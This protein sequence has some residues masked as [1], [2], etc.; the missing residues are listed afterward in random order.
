MRIPVAR[1]LLAPMDSLRP[2][3]LEIDA[4]RTYS[5]FGPLARRFE[6]RLCDH[7]SVP[8]GAVVS[9]ANATVGL[10]AALTELCRDGKKFCVMPAWTFC[11]TGH[12]AVMAGLQPYFVDVDPATW[13]I[14]PAI[15]SALPSDVIE[16]TAAVMVVGAFGAP[17]DGHAWDVFTTITGIPA[18]IDAAAGFDSLAASSTVSVVSLHATKALGIGEGGFVLANNAELGAAIRRRVSFGFANART[19]MVPGTNAKLSEYACAVGLASLDH[20]DEAQRQWSALRDLYWNGLCASSNWQRVGPA[21]VWV[22][23]T[24]VVMT[25]SDHERVSADLQSRDIDSRC[26]WEQ[27]CH[28]QP[29]F[30][31]SA[32]TLVP[33]TERLAAHSIGLPFYPDMTKDDVNRVLEVV[34]PH[35]DYHALGSYA[36]YPAGDAISGVRP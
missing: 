17:V 3:L 29:A 11:A 36:L 20:W 5:N 28:L 18:V 13:Q 6:Q 19:A 7:F 1:P 10:T 32:A 9:V 26:W 23:S 31:G 35:L 8:T 22:S 34:I 15:V 30:A 4:A 24:F 27:G 25:G 16:D 14:T 21:P 2:Y 33:V 12:A